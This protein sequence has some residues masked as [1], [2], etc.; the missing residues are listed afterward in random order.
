MIMLLCPGV[1][2]HMFSRPVPLDRHPFPPWWNS[3]NATPEVVTYWAQFA[4]WEQMPHIQRSSLVPAARRESAQQD[5]GS[6]S[7]SAS[8][9]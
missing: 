8:K 5:K 6:G 3:F 1:T 4:D 7:Q 2:Q 9:S